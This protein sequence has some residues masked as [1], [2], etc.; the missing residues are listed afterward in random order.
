MN[1]VVLLGYSGHSYVI[2]EI[3]QLSGYIISG[4]CE[5]TETINNPFNLDYLG[6]EANNKVE[7]N[8][9]RQNYYYFPAIGD[10]KKRESVTFYLKNLDLR[11]VNAIHPDSSISKK[12]TL[13]KGILISAGARVNPLSSIHDGAIFE[14]E[15]NIGKFSHIAPGAVL[16][17]NVIVGER[18]FVGANAIVK[19]GISIGSDVIIGAG[20]VVIH[21]VPDC[22]L[23]VGNPAKIK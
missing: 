18:S 2:A 23:V 22:S 3:L 16:V 9:I 13:G 11:P 7:Q 20:A 15:C 10:N 17:G 1:K 6:Y 4:Y 21:N 5:K 14:H 19:E 8:L 12:S